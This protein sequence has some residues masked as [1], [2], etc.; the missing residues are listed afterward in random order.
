MGDTS[1]NN[2]KVIFPMNAGFNEDN[3]T[4]GASDDYDSHTNHESKAYTS[5]S[6]NPYFVQNN[7]RYENNVAPTGAVSDPGTTAKNSANFMEIRNTSHTGSISNDYADKIGNRIFP[8]NET[9]SSHCETTE[10]SLSFKIKTLNHNLAT[11]NSETNRKFVYS[12]TDYPTTGEV[13]L[14]IK[15]RDYFILIN[16]ELITVGTEAI[17]PHFAKITRITSF[18]EFG[19]GL[20]FS[21]EYP[22]AIPAGTKFEIF[23]GPLKTDTSI[24]AVSYGLRGDNDATT[25]PKYDR[26]NICSRPTWY[27][28]NDRLDEN[29]QLDYMTKYTATHLRW[30]ENTTTTVTDVDALAQWAEGTTSIFYETSQANWNKL[31]EGQSIWS[32]VDGSLIGNI[33]HKFTTGGYRF[34]L[35]YARQTISA[36]GPGTQTL[37]VGKTAH[38]I[39]FRT[40]AKFNNTI[41]NLGEDRLDATLV[42]ANY[43]ADAS[44]TD[45]HRWHQAFTKMRRHSTNALNATSGTPDGNLTGPSKYVTFEKAGFK[46]NKIPLIQQPVLNDSRSKLTR[47]ASFNVMDNSGINHLKLTNGKKLKV[48]RNIYNANM[49]LIAF[50]GKVARNDSSTSTIILSDIRK[51]IDLRHILSTDDIILIDGYYYVVNVVSAQSSGTQ[52]FTIKDSKT[53]NATT[54]SGSAVAQDFDNKTMFL[55][56]YTG[57]INTGL[58]PDTEV[59][60]TTSRLSMNGFTVDKEHTKLFGSRFVSNQFTS[61]DNKIEHGDKDNKFLKMQ[62]S[63]RTFYQRSAESKDRF[64]YYGGGYAISDTPFTGTIEDVTSQTEDG[65]TMMKIAGRDD[66]SKLVSKTITKDLNVLSDIIYSS[67]NPILE[68]NITTD[69]DAG[70]ISVSGAELTY[71]TA[72]SITLKPYGILLDDEGIFVGEIKQYQTSPKKITLFRDSMVS[73]FSSSSGNL[74]YYHP[75]DGNYV[76]YVVGQKALAHNKLQ[77]DTTKELSTSGKGLVFDAGSQITHDGTTPNAYYTSSSG[78]FTFTNLQGTSNSGGILKDKTLGYDIIKPLNVGSLQTTYEVTDDSNFAVKIG[79]KNGVSSTPSNLGS[80]KSETFDVV[81]INEKG[82]G[83]TTLSIAPVFPVVMGRVTTN[84]SDARGN[85]NLYFVNGNLNSSGIL[86]RLGLSWEYPDHKDGEAIRYWD[87]QKFDAGTIGRNNDSIYNEGTSPQKIQGYAVGYGLRANGEKVSVSVSQTNKPISGS[88]TLKGWNNLGTYYA[89]YVDADNPHLIESYVPEV[90][91]TSFSGGPH[92]WDIDY[93][94]FEQIDPRTDY[95]DWFANGD[96]FPASNNRNN[97]I[98]YHTKN[99]EDFG[100]VLESEDGKTTTEVS[101]QEY[102]GKTKQTKKTENMFEAGSITKATKTTNQL[103]RFGVIRLVEATFDWHFN[104]VDLESLKKSED[105]PTIPYFDYVMMDNPTVRTSSNYINLIRSSQN[106]NINTDNFLEGDYGDMHYTKDSIGAS[107]RKVNSTPTGINGF[108]GVVTGAGW[109]TDDG[110]NNL[111]TYDIISDGANTGNLND[112]ITFTGIED[113]STIKHYGVQP[114]QIF[115]TSDFNIDNINLSGQIQHMNDSLENKNN[116]R[117][118]DVFLFRPDTRTKNFE[119]AHLDSIDNTAGSSTDGGYTGGSTTMTL[120]STSA[121]SSSGGFARIGGN[122]TTGSLFTYTGKSGNN[123]TGVS[124]VGEN[125]SYGTGNSVDPSLKYDAPNVILP[126]MTKDTT[127]AS[128]WDERRFSPFIH[129]E[130]WHEGVSWSSGGYLHM[131]RVVAALVERNFSN[132]T[133]IAIKDRFGVGIGSTSDAFFAHPYDNCIALF[134]DVKVA[135]E[136]NSVSM[137]PIELT[138]SVLK[139]DSD[140]NYEAYLGSGATTDFDQLTRTAMVQSMGITSAA[141][142][143]YVSMAG[144]TTDK[145]FLSEK[146]AISNDFTDSHNDM[147]GDPIG[148]VTSAQM[149]IK[150]VFKLR[151]DT[152]ANAKDEN[153]N[154]VTSLALTAPSPGY[155]SQMVFTL[156]DT[157]RHTWL[158]FL[159]NLTGYYLVSERLSLETNSDVRNTEANSFPYSMTRI[160]SHTSAYVSEIETHTIV[161]DNPIYCNDAKRMNWRLMR[162]S[163]TTFDEEEGY[164]EFNVLKQSNKFKRHDFLTGEPG[165]NDNVTDANVYSESIYTMHLMLDVDGEISLPSSSGRLKG[166][167]STTF[168]TK[169]IDLREPGQATSKFTNLEQLNMHISDGVTQ[170]VRNLTFA[171]ARPKYTD[172]SQAFDSQNYNG[173]TLSLNHEVGLVM[174]FDGK[175]SGNGVVSFGE[176]FDLDLTKRPKLQNVKK[177]H[178]GTTFSVGS[179]IVDEIKDIV[180]ESGLAFDNNSSFVEYTGNIVS[181]TS[182][183]VTE[184]PN[185]SLHDTITCTAN[186]EKISVGDV[187]YSQDGHLIGEISSVSS[188]NI[189]FT[190]NLRYVPAQHD[191]LVK[192]KEETYITSM[193]FDNVNTYD[194]VNALAAKN[195]LDFDIKNGKFTARKIDDVKAL[196]KYALSYKESNRLISVRNTESLFDRKNQ[197]VVIGDR[198]SFTLREPGTE[199]EADDSIEDVDPSIKTKTDAQ[200]RAVQLLDLH[201]KNNKVKKINIRTHKQGMELLECGDIVRLNFKSHNIPEDDYIVFEIENV[202]GGTWDLTVGTFDKSIAERLAEIN[203]KSKTSSASLFK[204]DGENVAIGKYFYDTISIREVSFSYEVSGSSNLLS[205]NSNMGFDDVVGFTEEVGF[206]HS[207]VTKKSYS[208]EL[209]EQEDYE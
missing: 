172:V 140:A 56:P 6:I 182:D 15:N 23:K 164:I 166:S 204:R 150:P 31:V 75:Y 194:V 157:S 63:D 40:E 104:P 11:A 141:S 36:F 124:F 9:L 143:E 169:S 110:N 191:E 192:I 97:N 186:V 71:S 55:T 113:G 206:E 33:K 21:P 205:Y 19:D 99:F 90:L 45:A 49:N 85:C 156:D 13:G 32:N 59:N 61:H 103:R 146:K 127:G 173:A 200:I 78:A 179:P 181:S 193:K 207:I 60:Y 119:F 39:V 57:V 54:W 138:S 123:L 8:K 176:I 159:P 101:H 52:S 175:L 184:S 14:D 167:D 152:S 94:A 88:N 82:E 42:D 129:P 134:K 37:K 53:V 118:T 149:L 77:T 73:S 117:F 43:T 177:C 74:K 136:D 144:T 154:T 81:T 153:F 107:P 115:T 120:H 84:T 10:E 87:F 111:V 96:L 47:M 51:E 100:I 105:I 83:V 17:R 185:D 135:M 162:V 189:V 147:S 142:G 114:F 69:L 174:K 130:Q 161:L 139:L 165:T 131:S 145:V 209:H 126:L 12:S 163:E 58:E 197:A 5:V 102:V 180:Q 4:V 44:I 70:A 67:L 65:M 48:Q 16:P 183:T 91:D 27:F 187:L 170:Q 108:V 198:V 109:Q 41:R 95:Y 28:Y 92:E 2:G 29:D 98:G 3:I 68:D 151:C 122:S 195:G 168:Q 26:V 35:D 125:K 196:R 64:Y 160:K 80:I 128:D 203:A 208:E 112:L 46:N 93:D 18:D 25:T 201:G 190:T 89:P 116:F 188:A 137:N 178:I 34:H 158:S 7:I 50:E 155:I 199:D 148:L 132:G 38:N 121:F 133:N 76:N 86:H 66:T 72:L 30:W 202:L 22:S 1:G 20:E 62:D 171:T 24:V 106:M 79:N